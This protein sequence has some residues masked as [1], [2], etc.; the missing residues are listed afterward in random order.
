VQRPAQS[1]ATPSRSSRRA[2]LETTTAEGVQDDD[3]NATE[4]DQGNDGNNSV[5]YEL[6]SESDSEALNVSGTAANAA[7]KAARLRLLVRCQLHVAL[8]TTLS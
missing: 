5:E 8:L 4:S 3:G 1:D 6:D 7:T 2:A